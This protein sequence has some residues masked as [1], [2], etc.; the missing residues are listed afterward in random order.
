MFFGTVCTE[1]TVFICICICILFHS[2]A[3]HTE[4]YGTYPTA[5]V[6]I[7]KDRCTFDGACC[8]FGTGNLR[9]ALQEL[10]HLYLASY[11]LYIPYTVY[12]I[13]RLF[14]R[15]FLVISQAPSSFFI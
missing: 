3:S 14:T 8:N 4:L 1:N 11:V 2:P 13:Y 15:V 12:Y 9:S 7:E 5:T 10:K 6:P